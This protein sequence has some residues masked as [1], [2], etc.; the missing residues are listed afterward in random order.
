MNI[1]EKKVETSTKPAIVSNTVLCEV[2]CDPFFIKTD[3]HGYCKQ[4]GKNLGYVRK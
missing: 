2:K 4:C 3:M 1:E